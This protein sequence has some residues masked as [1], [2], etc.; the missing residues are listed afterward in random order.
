MFKP[1]L[2]GL[3]TT[4][5]LTLERKKAPPPGLQVKLQVHFAIFP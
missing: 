2:S 5:L 4:R 3:S 1:E